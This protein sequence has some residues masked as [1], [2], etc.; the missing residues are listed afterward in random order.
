MKKWK[1]VNYQMNGKK[2]KMLS[3]K[4][5]K[6]LIRKKLKVHGLTEGSGVIEKEKSTYDNEEIIELILLTKCLKR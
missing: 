1:I 6:D 2:I 3:S 4:Q 5:R